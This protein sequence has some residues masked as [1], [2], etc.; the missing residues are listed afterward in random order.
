VHL[1][2][3]RDF[4]LAATETTFS[5]F[6]EWAAGQGRRL[7]DD[8]GYGRGERAVVNVTWEDAAAFCA[9]RGYRLPTEAEWEYAA[10][11]GGKAHRWS[12]TSSADSADA[13]VRHD[14]NGEMAATY[15]A[16]KKPNALGLYDMSGNV[17]E[18]VGPFYEF[19]PDDADSTVFKDLT[20]PGIRIVRGGSV[21]N[22]L[23]IAQT[24]W[25]SGT[26]SDATSE[27]IGFRCAAD[28]KK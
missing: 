27:M 6:D 17:F 13:F 20:V 18:W 23:D 2:T 16:T 28:H 1:V 24:F 15:V 22:P 9:A 8:E 19:Y 26:L 14:G 12:G 11:S 5:M 7:P 4:R 3:V 10:R 21:R 25:R